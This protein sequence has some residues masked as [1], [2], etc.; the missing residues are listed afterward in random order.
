MIVQE[1]YEKVMASN[2]LKVSFTKAAGST[3]ALDFWLK[4]HGF[5][6]SAEEVSAFFREHSGKPIEL[7]DDALEG[8]AGGLVITVD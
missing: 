8:V 7:S 2:E 1:I 6:A 3:A 5:E 4:E